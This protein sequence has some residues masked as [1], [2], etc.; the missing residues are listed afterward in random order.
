V[1]TTQ[2]T[3]NGTWQAERSNR[4]W[5]TQTV[6]AGYVGTGYL[7][8]VPD[9]DLQFTTSYTTTSP[10]LQYTLYF[11][12]TGVYTVWLRGYAPNAAGDSVYVGLDNQPVITLTGFLPRVWSW[13][14]AASPSG[15]A[16]VEITEPGLYTLNVWRREDGFRLDR[17]VLT[18]D[19]SYIPTGNGPPENQTGS[20]LRK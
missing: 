8:A 11:T 14:Q 2:A 6:L 4:G 7:N 3:A 13:S 17:I 19:N 15:I 16:T 10:E 20:L 1:A 18:T 12:N 5:L 9:T